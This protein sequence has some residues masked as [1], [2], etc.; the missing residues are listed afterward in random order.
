[1]IATT[2]TTRP[3][4]PELVTR[5]AEDAAVVR[6]DGAIA[7]LPRLLGE[8]FDLTATAIRASGAKIA[9][10][11]F[12]RYLTIGTEVSAEV[13]FPFDGDLTPTV[14]VYRT[15][16]PGGRAVRATH[17]GPYDEIAGTWEAIQ[18][19]IGAQGFAI[20]ATPWESYLTEP[21]AAPPVTEIVFP[22]A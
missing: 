17:I 4:T 3:S 6:I 1:M 11:P 16:L 18:A 19:W 20:R 21:D 14:R 8:A 13:G 12:A 15:T 2:R 10:P 9:G 7:D 22:V 5:R